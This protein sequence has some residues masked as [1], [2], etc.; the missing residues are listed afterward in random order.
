M[1]SRLSKLLIGFLLGSVAFAQLIPGKYILVLEDPPVLSRYNSRADMERP[2]ALAYRQQIEN[3]QSVIKRDL[4]SRNIVVTG[5]TSL[6]SNVIFVNAPASRLAEL[7]SVPGVADVRPMRKFKPTLD[8]ATQVLNGPAAWSA[9][10][11][12]TNAGLGIKIAI[13]DSG[14]DQTHP[15][16][17]DP[18]SRCPRAFPS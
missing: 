8:Q 9:L 15:A 17:Q 5:S 14:I 3:R 16:F 2:E 11:G 10:G 18:A 12:A 13:L 1:L 4:A 7:R 6:L